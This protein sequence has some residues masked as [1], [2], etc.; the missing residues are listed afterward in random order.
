[1]TQQEWLSY[2]PTLRAAHIAHIYGY[3]VSTVRK[4]A[5]QRNPKIPCPSVTRSFGW[6]RTDVQR[7]YERRHA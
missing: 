3:T 2:P 5:Q 1:M 6:N 7:H 4:Y